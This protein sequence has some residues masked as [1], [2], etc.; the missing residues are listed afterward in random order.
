MAYGT[1]R[2]HCG[3]Q[4]QSPDFWASLM[5]LDWDA[6]VDSP[7][8]QTEKDWCPAT[9][10]SCEGSGEALL[11]YRRYVAEDNTAR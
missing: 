2:R 4:E 9:R 11:L 5:D 8:S 10:H 6:M 3:G 1:R 7:H